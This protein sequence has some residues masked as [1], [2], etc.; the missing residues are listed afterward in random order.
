[1]GA[2]VMASHEAHQQKFFTVQLPMRFKAL[3]R[4]GGS[5]SAKFYGF[6]AWNNFLRNGF[7]EKAENR[8][9]PR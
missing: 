4:F 3:E 7:V 5:Q 9:L 8:R 2:V 6:Q 1:M